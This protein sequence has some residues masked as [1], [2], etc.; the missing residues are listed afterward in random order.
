[1][2]LP[3]PT[4]SLTDKG[5]DVTFRGMPARDDGESID[6]TVRVTWIDGA[7]AITGL[8]IPQGMTGPRVISLPWTDLRRESYAAAADVH[9][10]G[11]TDPHTGLT[12]EEAVKAS[13]MLRP[14]LPEFSA[15]IATLCRWATHTGSP[16]IATLAEASGKTGR[17]NIGYLAKAK[18]RFV[19]TGDPRFDPDGRA[20]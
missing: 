5:A 16:R 20:L 6:V 9:T 10:V 12:P 8:A 14:S 18:A 7:P 15:A 1:M 17:V 2:S 19:E 4:V 3:V 11:W 13:R